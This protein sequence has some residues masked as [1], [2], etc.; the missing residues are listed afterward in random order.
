MIIH[1][2][3]HDRPTERK[4]SLGTKKE[5]LDWLFQKVSKTTTRTATVTPNQR[6]RHLERVNSEQKNFHPGFRLLFVRHWRTLIRS[7]IQPSKIIF[8][9]PDGGQRDDLRIVVIDVTCQ[10][11]TF[12]FALPSPSH[13]FP[14]PVFHP[15]RIFEKERKRKRERKGKLT[16]MIWQEWLIETCRKKKNLTC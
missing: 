11:F 1:L 10:L 15:F 8:F 6:H 4:E 5:N 2:I 7:K 16:Q 9:C 3:R 14:P 13:L 12:S